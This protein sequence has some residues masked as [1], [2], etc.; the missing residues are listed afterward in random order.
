ME[1]TFRNESQRLAI[2][3]VQCA[4]INLGMINNRQR[5]PEFPTPTYAA[6]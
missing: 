4:S 5:L 1:F 3:R 2:D 6:I